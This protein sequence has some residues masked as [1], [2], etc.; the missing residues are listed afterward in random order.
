MLGQLTAVIGLVDEEMT[1]VVTNLLGV[2]RDAGNAIMGSTKI[3]DNTAIWISVIKQNTL[4]AETLGLIKHASREV[5][6]V[7]EGRNDYIHAVFRSE[8]GFF[9]PAFF[10][11]AIFDTGTVQARRVKR[12]K[13]KPLADLPPLLARACRLS[14]LVAHIS[15]LVK[16]EPSPWTN[17]FEPPLPPPNDASEV[18]RA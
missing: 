12:D 4:D 10:D 14:C 17:K 13:E 15:H 3:A 16:G 1:Q 11:P 9:D 2:D 5:Q 18:H 8:G 6:N 7:S